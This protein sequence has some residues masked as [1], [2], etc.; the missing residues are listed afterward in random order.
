MGSG[1]CGCHGY[2]LTQGDDYKILME[3]LP[4]A[5]LTLEGNSEDIK[6]QVIELIC[7]GVFIYGDPDQVS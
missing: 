4:Y 5:E 3:Y 1:T 6:R 2:D 7:S